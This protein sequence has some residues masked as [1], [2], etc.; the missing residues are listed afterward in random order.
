MGKSFLFLLTGL[1]IFQI[2]IGQNELKARLEYEEAEKAFNENKFED[3]VNRLNKAQEYLGKWSAK[4]GYLKIVALDNLIDY[5]DPDNKYSKLQQTEVKQYMDYANNNQKDVDVDKFKQVY[6]VEEKITVLKRVDAEQEMPEY[7]KADQYYEEKNYPEALQW[8][9]TSADRGNS[10]AM[11]R[12][13]QLNYTGT[14]VSENNKE[15]LA[16]FKKAAD[17]GHLRACLY[18]GDIYFFGYGVTIDYPEA[19]KWFKKVEGNAAA[20]NII[21]FSYD[22]GKGVPINYSEA[23]NWYKRSAD[24]GHSEAMFRIGHLYERG[25]GVAKDYTEAMNWYKK[26]ADKE[27]N[28]AFNSIGDLYSD[29]NGVTKSET[30]AIIWYKK[31]ADKGN[32]YATGRL[33]DIYYDNKNF[34]EAVKWLIKY[35]EAKEDATNT[36]YKLGELFYTGGFKDGLIHYP[37]QNFI[38]CIFWY[39][40]AAEKGHSAAMYNLWA[41]YRYG[42]NGFKEYK[43]RDK[44]K[45]WWS[46]YEKAKK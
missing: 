33:G 44:A 28:L 29:G 14:G 41:I 35:A 30:E 3:A 36:M 6:T 45:E 7:K 1:F 16:W 32:L 42:N 9:K 17:N 25:A 5:S 12:M 19:I 38:K 34:D 27:N 18:I 24:K 39:T 10:L 15:A 2:A 26:S 4:I 13:G 37:Q 8:F 43:D 22:Y 40:K 20:M 31:S 46:K 21:G 11:Y 23:I